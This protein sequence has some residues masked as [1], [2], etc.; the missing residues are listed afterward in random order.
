MNLPNYKVFQLDLKAVD[1]I[2]N[3][4]KVTTPLSDLL[5]KKLNL[6]KGNVF[7]FFPEY[8]NN[9]KYKL[10]NFQEGGILYLDKSKIVSSLK[11]TAVEVPRTTDGLIEYILKYVQKDKNN[12]VIVENILAKPEYEYIKNSKFDIKTIDDSV[13]YI[14]TKKDDSQTILEILKECSSVPEAIGVFSSIENKEKFLTD[15]AFLQVITKNIFGL[16]IEAY[17]HE[18]Y[19]IWEKE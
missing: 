11:W 5:N 17:D 10:E 13:Y 3:R 1:F 15:E 6:R 4:L 7:T 16:F 19:L 8:V 2:R 12:I 9:D 18:G 14:L